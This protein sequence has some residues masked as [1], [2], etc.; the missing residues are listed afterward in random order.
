MLEFHELADGKI[1]D[2]KLSGKL[3]TFDYENFVPIIERAIGRHGRVRI[4]C[5][6]HDFHGWKMGALW[7]DIK[8]DFKH[9]AD[10]ERVA[11]VGDRAWQHGMALFCKPF[12]RATVRY[13]DETE[14]R[15][16]EDWIWDGMPLMSVH[17]RGQAP[18][19][20]VVDEASR[21]S[22]PASDSPAY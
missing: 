21:E 3:C 4:L 16:A 17:P 10:I 6:M 12:T 2:V 11:F 5:Q 7:Q 13:F 20:D 22:F 19:M 1:L 15:Q 8:F 18:A 14:A 9:F